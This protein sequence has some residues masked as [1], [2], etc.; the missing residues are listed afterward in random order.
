MYTACSELV[1]LM[2]WTHNS[3]NNLLSYW[4]LS[5]YK[6]KCF[7]KRFTCKPCFCFFFI[8]FSIKIIWL[9]I[10]NSGYGIFET[11]CWATYILA[12]NFA[13]FWISWDFLPIFSILFLPFSGA[14]LDAYLA[15][16]YWFLCSKN[17]HSLDPRIWH[18]ERKH[19]SNTKPFALLKLDY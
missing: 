15:L 4:G 9:K 14:L 3:M 16:L 2:Y 10:Q 8:L 1:I 12:L 18:G 11:M 5:W 13:L 17:L 6:N 7:W 19:F